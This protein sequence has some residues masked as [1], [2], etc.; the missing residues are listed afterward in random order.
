MNQRGAALPMVIAGL[1]GI[2]ALAAAGY[3]LARLRWLEGESALRSTAARLAAAGA[4]E[5]ALAQWDVTVAETLAAGQAVAIP[6][7][8]R[9]RGVTT[10]DSLIHLG[11]GLYLVRSVGERRDAGGSL[12]ARAAV[13]R[14]ARLATPL[15]SDSQAVL[16]AG[17][18]TVEGSP[19]V[20]GSDQAPPGWTGVCPPASTTGAGIRLGAGGAAT[21]TC[22]SGSCVIGAPPVAV[23]SQVTGSTV[24]ALGPISLVDLVA[25]ADLQVGGAVS[26]V[27]PAEVG[28]RCDRDN[29][30]NWGD[31]ASVTTP[32]GSYFPVIAAQPGT[33]VSGGVGQGI[34]ASSGDLELAGDFVFHGVVVAGGAVFLRD[35]AR[36]VGTVIARDSVVVVGQAQAARSVCAVSRALASARRPSGRVERG[37]SLWP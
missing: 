6:S 17:P 20:D 31:P 30:L 12:L 4:V 22:T 11:A 3:T 18:V 10:Y 25:G 16:S 21:I 34:L 9:G 28:G 13:A 27:A 36:A 26:V 15:V 37:W 14:L 8:A 23:D 24:L 35:R 1:L 33:R 29:E 32:C 5:R 2:S 19:T 7:A